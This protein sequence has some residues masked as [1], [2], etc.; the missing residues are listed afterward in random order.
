MFIIFG[1]RNSCEQLNCA[2]NEIQCERCSNI[3]YY[4][5]LRTR[6]WF[7]LFFIPLIPFNTKYYTSC[8]ICGNSIQIEKEQLQNAGII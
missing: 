1:T 4:Q 6:T 5:I 2:Q 7:T 8:P 3:T